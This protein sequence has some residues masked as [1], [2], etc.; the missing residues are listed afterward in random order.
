MLSQNEEGKEGGEERIMRRRKNIS[1][2]GKK[3][4]FNN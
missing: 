1:R 2:R 3:E 4:T